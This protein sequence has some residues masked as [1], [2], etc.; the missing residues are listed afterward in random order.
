M[1]YLDR[2]PRCVANV[3]RSPCISVKSIH[4]SRNCFFFLRGYNKRHGSIQAVFWNLMF[5]SG[6]STGACHAHGPKI[7]LNVCNS[8]RTKCASPQANVPQSSVLSP[9]VSVLFAQI[10]VLCPLISVH[11]PPI[12]VHFRFLHLNS[13]LRLRKLQTCKSGKEAVTRCPTANGGVRPEAEL[14]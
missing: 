6:P 7:P 2:E 1:V 8:P 13:F 14:S 4:V 10:S 3:R 9:Q 12:S 5:C 11:F